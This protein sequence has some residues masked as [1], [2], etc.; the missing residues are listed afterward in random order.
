[1]NLLHQS[2]FI[3]KNY[4]N[5]KTDGNDSLTGNSSIRQMIVIMSFGK[6]SLIELS[7]LKD[8]PR[9]KTCI[10][11]QRDLDFVQEI[12]FLSTLQLKK[13]PW[14][15]FLQETKKNTNP[16]KKFQKVGTSIKTSF[17]VSFVFGKGKRCKIVMFFIFLKNTFVLALAYA[18]NVYLRF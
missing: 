15:F 14:K 3:C 2:Y 9:W 5:F 18:N 8:Q 11:Q 1:M 10:T 6:L 16:Q 17:S 7:Y 13:I 4:R 12:V